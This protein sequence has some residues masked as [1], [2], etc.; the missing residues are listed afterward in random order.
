MEKSPALFYIHKCDVWFLK[1]YSVNRHRRNMVFFF[2]LLLSFVYFFFMTLV[3]KHRPV[4]I[5]ITSVLK[6][7]NQIHNIH[8]FITRGKRENTGDGQSV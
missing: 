2:F 4:N 6:I 1:H 5:I 7:R 8:S 3:L